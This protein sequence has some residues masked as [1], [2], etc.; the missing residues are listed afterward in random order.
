MYLKVTL[1]TAYQ[2]R[3][4]VA[5]AAREDSCTGDVPTCQGTRSP[6]RYYSNPQGLAPTPPSE[7]TWEITLGLPK[8]YSSNQII[9]SQ[10]Q[11]SS[12]L[13]TRCSI[14]VQNRCMN[15]HN[16]I[17]HETKRDSL[18]FAHK[19]HCTFIYCPFSSVS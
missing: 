8:W 11:T 18:S 19:T 4:A 16:C 14:P 9:H 12:G 6:K 1:F 5:L 7:S 17:V 3:T 2:N 13:S 10:G 15:Y